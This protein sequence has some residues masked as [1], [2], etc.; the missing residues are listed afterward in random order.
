MR[1]N[2]EKYNDCFRILWGEASD[3]R[4]IMEFIFFLLFIAFVSNFIND[5]SGKNKKKR[6]MQNGTRFN[7]YVQPGMTPQ[8]RRD[9]FYRQQQQ[10]FGNMF[11]NI[12][13][14]Q[15][16]YRTNYNPYGRNT[17]GQA[18]VQQ[19]GRY[20]NPYTNTGRMSNYGS[21]AAPGTI[22]TQ[23]VNS[24]GLP[25]AAKKRKKIVKKFNERFDLCLTE[26]EIDQIVG[27]SYMD[28]RWAREICY[29]NQKY[30]TVYAWFATS[31]PWLKAYMH[32]FPLQ[33]ISSDFSM[34]EQ[35]VYNAFDQIFSDILTKPDI[36]VP[37]AIWQINNKYYTRFDESSFMIA[38]RFMEQKG[39]RYHLNLVDV[40][41]GTEDIDSLL[42]KYDQTG[43]Q[44]LMR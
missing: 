8:Q 24:F 18:P 17:A 40:I 19:P 28:S 11:N 23:S 27:A 21:P 7:N 30:E 43:Q 20:T 5:S 31:N 16:P 15:N 32:A 9:M 10:L 44:Q 1:Y 14:Q 33:Q 3:R 13:T 29:M 39:K 41:S 38:Y 36:T 25:N 26:N 22:A 35:I 6:N 12:P 2:I 34:Q 42:S 37:E 4:L